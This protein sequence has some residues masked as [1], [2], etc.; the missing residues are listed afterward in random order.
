MNGV[1]NES[2]FSTVE[3]QYMPAV[4][5]SVRARAAEIAKENSREEANYVDVFRAFE[6]HFAGGP[7]TS[8]PPPSIW[9]ENLFLI[10]V[11]VMTVIF[12]LMALLPYLT[13]GGGVA[14]PGKF[15]YKPEV[16]LDIAKLFAGVVVGGAAGVAVNAAGRRTKG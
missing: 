6:Q 4:L 1:P 5:D 14:D 7:K 12:G 15:G 16:F 13:I 9:R 2:I 3:K 8:A 11:V 10:I